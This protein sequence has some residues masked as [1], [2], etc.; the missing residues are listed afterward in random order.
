MAATRLFTPAFAMLT[1]VNLAYFTAAGM[2]L[3]A[4]PFLVTGPLM[5]STAAVGLV[6]GSF[7]IATLLVRPYIGRIVDRVGRRNR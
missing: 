4:T 3:F 2:V 6:I 7:S 1:V 5:S